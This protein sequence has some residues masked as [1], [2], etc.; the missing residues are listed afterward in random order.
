MEKWLLLHVPLKYDIKPIYARGKQL[1]YVDS[2]GTVPSFEEDSVRP[3]ARF[4]RNTCV[5]Y[6]VEGNFNRYEG[7]AMMWFK[8]DWASDYRDE[9]GRI[10]WD[11]RIEYGSV[12]PNDPS[13]RWAI[14][15]P[16]LPPEDADSKPGRPPETLQRWRFCIAT[17]RNRY[18]IGTQRHRPDR[19]SRQ[20][21]WGSQQS[22]P[23]GHWMHIAVSWT[24]NEGVIFVNAT[25]DARSELAE[26][27][28]W[29]PLPETMQLGAVSSW[30]NAGPCGVIADFRIYE[31]ALGEA[32]IGRIAGLI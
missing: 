31:R 13:Q 30:I 22:F 28:P 19:R 32:E 9:L 25:E 2:Q 1:A 17:D 10:L 4:G 24:E 12:V 20:A 8:P 23:A 21:V 5:R 15:Y 14:V 7:T 3:G 6:P 27:L 11:L 18:I 26:G 29:R 16:S